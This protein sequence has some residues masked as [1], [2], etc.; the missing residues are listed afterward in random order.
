M[1]VDMATLIADLAAEATALE[2]LLGP[3]R[4]PE[5]A[6]A[7]PAPGWS[8]SDQVIHLAIFDERAK[9]SITDQARFQSDVSELMSGV[10]VHG[11]EK[12]R[13][14]QSVLEWWV[15]G[16]ETLRQSVSNVDGAVRCPWYGPSMS[17]ASLITARIM[18]TWAH[19]H[20][21][22]DAIGAPVT[23]TERLRH[24]AH[25]GVRARP[26]SYAAHRLDQPEGDVRVELVGPRGD[27]WRWGDGESSD[28]VRGS[29][30]E[31]CQV[32]TRRRHVDDTEL[33]VSGSAAREWMEIAQA[34]AGPPG[35]GRRPG[36]FRGV[37]RDSTNAS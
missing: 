11:R 10:D 2:T 15:S 9:W 35:D 28:V 17:A 20:D 26:F 1:A 16:N 13:T 19:A 27:T 25:I 6:T 31:F 36:Q 22:A 3:L 4:A 30:L 32:V 23:A 33:E 37:G 34:F 24:V 29:A 7:T 8:I 21:V 18:E 14:P 12:S 5:W